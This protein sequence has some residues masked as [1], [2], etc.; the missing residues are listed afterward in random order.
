M[1]T[2]LLHQDQADL[3]HYIEENHL[4]LYASNPSEN[5]DERQ[6]IV[7]NNNTQQVKTRTYLVKVNF[8]LNEA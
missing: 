2:N 1:I 4:A 5:T 3:Q 7:R 8:G 6:Y